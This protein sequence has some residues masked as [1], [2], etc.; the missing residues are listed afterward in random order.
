MVPGPQPAVA[1][2]VQALAFRILGRDE[3]RAREVAADN[4]DLLQA[5][6]FRPLHRRTRLLAFKA[7]ENAAS[8][9]EATTRYV[10]GRMREALSLPEKRYPT[11]KLVGLIATVLHRW[12]SL[13]S[14]DEAPLI[15]GEVEA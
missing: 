8:R 13:R 7:L 2:G 6:L 10:L 14:P 12:P 15:Y 5:T 11:E 1:G 9:D 4:A 3:P